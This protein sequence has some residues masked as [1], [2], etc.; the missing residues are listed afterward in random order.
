VELASGK[1]EAVGVKFEKVLD[2]GMPIVIGFLAEQ[3][4]LGGI[5]DAIRGIVDKLRETVDKALIWLIDK[6]K[7]G[8]EALMNLVQAGIKKL[9]DWW[10]K[11]IPLEGGPEKHTLKFQGAD[12][13]AQLV[14]SSNPKPVV[15]F[16]RDYVQAF[17]T[18]EGSAKQVKEATRL[19]GEISKTQ[20]EIIAAEA[21]GDDAEV[22]RLTDELNDKLEKLG[23][24]LMDL[25]SGSDEGSKSSPVLIDY[26]KR[27]AEAYPDIYIGPRVGEG[28]RIKQDWL[29]DLFGKTNKKA[30]EGL[31]EDEPRLKKNKGFDAWDDK[32]RKLSPTGSDTVDGTTVG[33][34]PQIAMLGP[35]VKII[36]KDPGSTGGGHKIND[37]FKPYGFVPSSKGGEGMDGDHVLERQLGGPDAIP[38]LWPLDRSENRSSGSIIKS[39]KYLSGP[40]QKESKITIHELYR[41]RG[42]KELYLVIRGVRSE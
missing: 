4:G 40:D 14:V 39:L 26:P 15:V 31:E 28:L 7:A 1:W 37:V 24:I 11:E 20:K 36:Y 21:K 41:K 17:L 10:K 22:D 29:R 16:V 32:V 33:L 25:M 38:N 18:E 23:D 30:K 5:G 19:D 42:E 8:I 2:R 27:R 35:G 9:K 13:Q 12:A 3:V 6:I 34:D